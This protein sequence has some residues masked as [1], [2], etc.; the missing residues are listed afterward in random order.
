MRN[1]ELKKS[2]KKAISI[3]LALERNSFFILH[4][5][6]QECSGSSW[7]SLYVNYITNFLNCEDENQNL[8]DNF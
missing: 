4:Y 5:Y 3:V 2:I 1:E 8:Y 6:I 7:I